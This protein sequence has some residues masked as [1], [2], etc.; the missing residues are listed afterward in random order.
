MSP[1]GVRSTISATVV[2]MPPPR[3]A[4]RGFA[5]WVA[6]ECPAGGRVLN[7]GAGHNLSGTLRPVSRVAGTIVGID[8]DPAVLGNTTLHEAQ[9]LT[10]EAYA[11]T[12]PEPFDLAFSVFVLEHVSDPRAFTRACAAVLRPGGVLMGMTVNKWHYFGL[13]TWA[14]TRAH[15]A[16]PLLRRLRPVEQVEGYHFPTE[17][18]INTTRA[19][20]AHLGRAGFTDVEF[21]LWDLPSMYE[22][23]LPG[24]VRG[25]ASTYHDWVY[26]RDAAR[27]MGHLTFRAHLPG[28]AG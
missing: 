12:D 7:I 17:Y 18:R 22:P 2:A 23:Y 15:V 24:P 27:L 19:V 3:V 5:R 8:P 21:R 9:A 28:G 16:E 11:A 26:R 10:M 14:A 13:S 20:T 1:V 4:V 25:F 6:R